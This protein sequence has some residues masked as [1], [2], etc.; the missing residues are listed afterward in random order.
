MKEIEGRKR[1][2]R[3]EEKNQKRAPGTNFGPAAKQVHGPFKNPKRYPFFFFPSLTC[4]PQQPGH[5]IVPN[6]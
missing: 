4:G 6:L 1:K 5:I 2:R 3:E